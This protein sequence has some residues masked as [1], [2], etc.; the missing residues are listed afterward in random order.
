VCNGDPLATMEATGQIDIPGGEQRAEYNCTSPP[1]YIPLPLYTK[2]YGD[3]A[4]KTLTFI[5][6]NGQRY[7]K[8][9]NDVYKSN[10]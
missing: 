7:V 3:M 1:W 6:V 5:T 8:I 4:G 9:G 2:A 10:Y